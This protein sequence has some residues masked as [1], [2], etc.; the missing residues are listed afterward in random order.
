MFE[1]G[2]H[3]DLTICTETAKF[4]VH[5]CV[6]DRRTTLLRSENVEYSRPS[7]RARRLLPPVRYEEVEEETDTITLNENETVVRALLQHIYEL[8]VRLLHRTPAT[9]DQA[10][11]DE[12]VD[13]VNLKKAANEYGVV[14]L[15]TL[16]AAEQRLNATNRLGR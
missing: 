12:F 11:R 15:N 14:G 4:K 3:S 16:D 6:V 1:S 13:L 9:S 10:L 2:D 5:K 7:K 8:E